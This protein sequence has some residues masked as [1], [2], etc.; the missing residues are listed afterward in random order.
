MGQTGQTDKSQHHLMPPTVYTV[1]GWST[2]TGPEAIDFRLTA[3]WTSFR[4]LMF[5]P[6]NLQ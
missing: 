2:L 6:F 1:G 4:S 3:I 5:S